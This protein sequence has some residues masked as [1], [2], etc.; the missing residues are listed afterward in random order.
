MGVQDI[1]ESIPA[2]AHPMDVMRTAC[3]ALGAMLPEGEEHKLAAARDIA[4]RLMASFGSMLLYWYH[5]SHSGRRIEVE[6]DDDSIGGGL[7]PHLHRE[8]KP[9]VRVPAP[10]HCPHHRAQAQIDD[11]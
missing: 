5:F 4:D 9:R 10:D 3:S 2:S 11:P 6:T 1:L 7:P 8:E